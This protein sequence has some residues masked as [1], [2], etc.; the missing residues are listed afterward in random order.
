VHSS[1]SQYVD[2]ERGKQVFNTSISMF[3]SCSIEDNDIYG[4]TTK[5]LA[6][7]WSIHKDLFEKTQ[8]PPGLSLK[9]RLF[10]SI[11]HDSLWQW[12]EKYSG[13]PNN[14]AP[15]LPPPFMSPSS[16]STNGDQPSAHRP[17]SSSAMSPIVS[18]PDHHILQ[19]PNT[20]DNHTTFSSSTGQQFM[21]PSDFSDANPI[22]ETLPSVTEQEPLTRNIGYCPSNSMQFDMLFPDTVMG[23]ADP[24]QTWMYS[25]R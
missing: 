2:T 22:R 12:R 10:F 1:Y 16:T 19:A 15:S 3:R 6:Q 7:L 4:R 23:Y 24:E 20:F 13:Q 18:M 5:V 11:A 9:S 21:S 14:G 8:Q 25:V 17:P